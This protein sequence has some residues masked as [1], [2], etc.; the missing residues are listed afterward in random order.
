MPG[1]ALYDWRNANF[2]NDL[3]FPR[4]E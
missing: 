4:D 1:V 2:E 3:V